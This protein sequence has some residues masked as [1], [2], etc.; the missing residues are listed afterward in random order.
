MPELDLRRTTLVL[1]LCTTGVLAAMVLVSAITGATQEAHEYYAPPAEYAA[2]LLAHPGGLRAVMGLDLAFLTLYTA[3]FAALARHLARPL[4]LLALGFLV[5]VAVLDL[6]EDHQI[7]TAL[8]IAE[9]GQPIGDTWPAVQQVLSST[10]FGLS[11]VGLF[12]YGVAIPRTTK[13]AWALSL[14]LTAG[15]V[16]T[17]VLSVAAPVEMRA[18]LDGG[19]WVSFLVGFVL[20]AAWL[21]AEAGTSSRDR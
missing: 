10:K 8:N 15:V 20:I 19:R 16:V 2:S 1:V 21:R 14:F 7:L 12:L 5:G 11:Y 3:M 17:A 4:A 9:R 6:I 18:S 13:L